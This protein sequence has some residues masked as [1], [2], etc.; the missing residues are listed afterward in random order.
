M[1]KHFARL[2]EKGLT[3]IELLAVIV[4]LGIV[5]A[6][7]TISILNVVQKSRDKAFVGNAYALNEAA[8]YFVKH[9]V[10]SGNTLAQRI[11]FSMVSK[12]G[13]ME[14]FK[15]PY[16]GNYI[17]PSDASYVEVEGEHIRTVCLYGENRNLCSYNGVSGKPIPV[18]E[19]SVDMIVKDN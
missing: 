9:E 4:I 19:L 11:T 13:F 17:E 18:R 1:N 16:T 14:A 7:A 3:L 2:N 15:D 8:S 5:A 12:A 6:I 10:T